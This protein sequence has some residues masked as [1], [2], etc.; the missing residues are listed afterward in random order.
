MKGF[1]KQLAVAAVASAVVSTV[2]TFCAEKVRKAL[3]KGK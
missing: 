3:S 2:A 1:L